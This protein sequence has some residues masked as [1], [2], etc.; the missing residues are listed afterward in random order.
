[1]TKWTKAQ[2]RSLVD[3]MRHQGRS[4]NEIAQEIRT[5]CGITPLAAY[6]QL[7]GWS[8]TE[9]A[10]RYSKATPGYG[11]DQATLSRLELWPSKGGRA[12]QALQIVAFAKLYGAQP[13]NLLSAE[14]FERLGEA[15]RDVLLRVGQE[16]GPVK[17]S[18]S[19]TGRITQP[20]TDEP[21]SS[22]R[23]VEMAARRA[24]RFGSLVEGSNTGPETIQALYEETARISSVYPRVPLGDVLS[25]LIEAQDVAFRQLEGRQRPSQSKDLYVLAGILSIMLAKAPTTQATPNPP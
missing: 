16:N 15:E 4:D 8:Q 10:A 5:K 3:R 6:R 12:P 25:D 1:M 17:A 21:S 14:G 22:E 18:H 9:A 11:V 20:P 24:L 2:V 19:L 13:L 23:Q 7:H